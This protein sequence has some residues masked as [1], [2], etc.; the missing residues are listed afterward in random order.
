ML[1]YHERD[2]HKAQFNQISGLYP[3]MK[4]ADDVLDYRGYLGEE[5]PVPGR[6]LR[7]PREDKGAERQGEE[8]VYP[9]I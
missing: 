9:L 6:E 3:F 5:F 8:I 7:P 2:V 1:L 4:L